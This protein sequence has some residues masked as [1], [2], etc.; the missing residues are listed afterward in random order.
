[1]K[2]GTYKVSFI[3]DLNDCDTLDDAEKAIAG[4]VSDTLDED[5]F[6]ELELELVDEFDIEYHTEEDEVPELD[7]GG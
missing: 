4:L 6:P 7:F 5:T 2:S 3:V 1:M